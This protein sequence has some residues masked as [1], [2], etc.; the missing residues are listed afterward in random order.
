MGFNLFD[1][2]QYKMQLTVQGEAFYHKAKPLVAKYRQLPTDIAPILDNVESK[3][4]VA[5][6]IALDLSSVT[7]LFKKT[8]LIYQHTV[9]HFNQMDYLAS[10][11]SLLAKEVDLAVCYADTFHIDLEYICLSKINMLPVCNDEYL[12]TM[13]SMHS[14][15]WMR[16]MIEGT[17]FKLQDK[18]LMNNAKCLVKDMQASKQMILA[19]LGI[20]RLPKNLIKH[21]IES[22]QLRLLPADIALPLELSIYK[23]RNKQIEHGKVAQFLWNNLFLNESD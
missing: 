7:E 17:Y 11:R 2:S 12:Q 9:F 15:K 6:D 5:W 4:R 20:G 16:I 22:G 3:I 1:R 23:I 18:D 21:E 14:D 10:I 13:K 19:G 8:T